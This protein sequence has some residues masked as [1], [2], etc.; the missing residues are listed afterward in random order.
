MG[1]LAIILA[2]G[3]CSAE[4]FAYSPYKQALPKKTSAYSTNTVFMGGRAEKL[5][6]LM[7]VRRIHSTKVGLER[8]ILDL[9]SED[10]RPMAESGY[11]HVS[12]DG[13]N[14]RVVIQ[15]S[16]MSK[17][18]T[19]EQQLRKVFAK[20]KFVKSVDFTVDPEDSTGTVVL[21]LKKPM[22]AEVFS[23]SGKKKQTARLILDL[24]R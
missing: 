18:L 9:G 12:V 23:L 11:F 17:T 7:R 14:S 1:K 15:L 6:S 10:Y 3:I 13:N 19:N 16:Q 22:K 24:K 5:Q 20:S 2:L 8:V 21:N 4:V